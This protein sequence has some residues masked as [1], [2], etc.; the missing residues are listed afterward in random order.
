M[1]E[2]GRGSL[3]YTLVSYCKTFFSFDIFT[4]FS[5]SRPLCCVCELFMSRS[6]GDEILLGDE[7]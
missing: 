4:Y 5:Y 6:F 3:L 1:A 7:V 2:E